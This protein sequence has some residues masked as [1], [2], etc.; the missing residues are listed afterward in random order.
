MD[1]GVQEAVL[2]RVFRIFTISGDSMGDTEKLFDMA[3]AK[4]SIGS[5][6]PVLGRCDQLLVGPR[7]KVAYRRGIARHRERFTHHCNDSL[8]WNMPARGFVSLFL[9]V[10]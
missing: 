7:S 9:S 2:H 8:N 5:G 3:L 1:E 4:L 10:H 6:L